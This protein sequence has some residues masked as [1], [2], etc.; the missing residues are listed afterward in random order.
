MTLGSDVSSDRIQ[1]AVTDALRI[2]VTI[3]PPDVVEALK[4]SRARETSDLAA[5]QLDVI[6]ENVAIAREDSIPICQDTGVLTFFVEAGA[7]SPF[8]A[9]IRSSIASAVIEATERIPLRPNTVDPF[10]GAN[11]GDNTGRCMPIIDWEIVDGD[12]IRITVLPKGGGSENMSTLVMLPPDAGP[13]GIKRAVVEH[14]V[15]CRGKPCPP[16][17]VGV[18]IGGGADVAMK[19][20]KK[21]LLREIGSVHPRPEAA[22]LERELLELINL[23][24]VGP[25]GLGGETTSLAVHV[26]YAHRHPASLP[27][28]IVV[29]CW[30]DR[31]AR[32][33]VTADGTVGVDGAVGADATAEAA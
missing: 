33:T 31:R 25:M 11:P 5:A 19:L 18:G 28:G 27:L 6:L 4:R 15:A 23:S 22:Q 26:E 12:E 21:A 3:L 17:I 9:E 10:T 1:D 8:L 16:T 14:V 30:A 29:Q 13:K 7:A 32:V 2:A 24:G 20:G